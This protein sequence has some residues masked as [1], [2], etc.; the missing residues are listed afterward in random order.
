[1]YPDLAGYNKVE[2]K[3]ASEEYNALVDAAVK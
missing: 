2:A 3:E 1:M